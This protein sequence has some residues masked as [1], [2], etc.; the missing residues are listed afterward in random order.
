M[1]NR[2]SPARRETIEKRAKELILKAEVLCALRKD[3]GM[4]PIR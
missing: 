1:L 3:Q 2:L 4:W